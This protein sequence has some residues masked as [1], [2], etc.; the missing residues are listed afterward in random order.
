LGTHNSSAGVRQAESVNEACDGHDEE[1]EQ[2]KSQSSGLR[3]TGELDSHENE[4]TP[5]AV[6]DNDL[7]GMSMIRPGHNQDIGNHRASQVYDGAHAHAHAHAPAHG[8][9][10]NKYTKDTM[11]MHA[12]T[13]IN[14]L[15]A[16]ARPNVVGQAKRGTRGYRQ[17]DHINIAEFSTPGF[18]LLLR[19]ARIAE[20]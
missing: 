11:G 19:L 15:P 17:V 1:R 10:S 8:Q 2:S 18:I 12:G 16:P 20:P 6:N 13:R 7:G 3:G 9:D 14:H 4:E 5:S